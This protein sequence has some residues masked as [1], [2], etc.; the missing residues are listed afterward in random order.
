MR[1]RN[2]DAS[3]RCYR[4]RSRGVL[5]ADIPLLSLMLSL[6]FLLGYP[7]MS[8]SIAAASVDDSPSSLLDEFPSTLCS[9]HFFVRDAINSSSS[10]GG[11]SSDSSTGQPGVLSRGRGFMGAA[12][13]AGDPV[14]A[15][16]VAFVGGIGEGE[17]T[18]VVE[19]AVDAFVVAGDEAAAS[20][21]GDGGGDVLSASSDGGL[22]VERDVLS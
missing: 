6:L 9:R 3:A 17:T 1:H 7:L 18:A 12:L 14:G 21:A 16:V 11:N 10:I 13:L 4:L 19:N 8:A 15:L 5:A 20:T 22:G 2:G